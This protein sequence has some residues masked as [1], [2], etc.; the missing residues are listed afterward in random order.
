[1]QI[2][3][4]SDVH[5][6]I[7]THT[8]KNTRTNTHINTHEYT[9]YTRTSTHTLIYIRPTRRLV[10]FYRLHHRSAAGVPDVDLAH[11][12]QFETAEESNRPQTLQ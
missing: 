3:L 9:T 7:Q 11:A 10:K 8:Q 5:V 6:Y 12:Q 2:N 1:M 4:Y